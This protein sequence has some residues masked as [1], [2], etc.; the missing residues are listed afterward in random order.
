[1]NSQEKFVE[2]LLSE[3]PDDRV[4]YQKSVPTFHP[5]NAEE[6]SNCFKLANRYNQRLFIAGFGNNISPEGDIFQGVISVK[7]DRLN[8][9]LD[10]VPD[11]YYVR[12]G[13]GFP[14]KEINTHLAKV[15]LWLPHG[16]LPYVGSVGG[17]VAVGLNSLYESHDLPLKKY[18]IESEIVTPDGAIIKPGSVCFKSVSG[19]DIVRIFAGSWGLLGMIVS[20]TFRVMPETGAEDYG[21]IK[22]T[23]YTNAT[24][25]ES[26]KDSN[27][28]TDAVYSKKIKKKFDPNHILPVLF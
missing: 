4:T 22:M 16:D 9:I 20:A 24:L 12:L 17:A 14:L 3:F 5:E 28:D 13:G 25:K 18:Y 6:V 2:I 1:M 26:F 27:I 11:D 23:G 21:N 19:Y 7:S 10:I 15:N 8:Q